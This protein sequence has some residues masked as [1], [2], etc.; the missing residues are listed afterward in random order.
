MAN[1][2]FVWA[3]I[4]TAGVLVALAI[5]AALLSLSGVLF[6]VFA[7]IFITLGLDPLVRWFERRGMRRGFAIVTVI[8]LFVLV[9]AGLLW[10]VVPLVVSQA[11]AFIASLP[12]LYAKLQQQDWYQDA[13]SG[14]G[15][16]LGNVYAWFV[17]L[18]ADP[19]TW[20]TIGGGALDI[21]IAIIGGISSGFF[22]FVL[23]IYF[24]ATL[25]ASKAAISTLVSAS[26][27]ARV[28]DYAERIMQNVGRYLSGMV[29][30]AFFNA[31]YSFIL[32]TLVGQPFALVIS[33]AAFFITLIPLIGTVLTT[34]V[35]TALTLFVSP[36]AALI[37]L[38]AMLVYMQ[39]EA[40]ILTPRVMSKAVQVPGSIVLIAAL[41]GGTLAG[42]PGALVAIPVAAGILLIVKEVVVPWKART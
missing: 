22:I 42:L 18:L 4:A 1:R 29:I 37:V 27:R 41:A 34:I 17:D 2:P 23:T 13:V 6:S 35:M 8:V 25:D 26:H 32:L 24:I 3:F 15:G 30:L 11:A 14:S 31:T 39:V 28:V 10:V 20:A 5:A 19:T 36:T 9:I 12:D 33:V 40:Y 16:V 38:V 21:G 7:A